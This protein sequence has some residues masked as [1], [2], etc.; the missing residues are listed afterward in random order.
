MYIHKK[1]I[2]QVSIFELYFTR[3]TLKIC[4]HFEP[5]SHQQFAFFSRNKHATCFAS[6]NA[7]KCIH[8]TRLKKHIV[9]FKT[10]VANKNKNRSTRIRLVASIRS[11]ESA[12]WRFA[13]TEN[14]TFLATT[15]TNVF[16][17]FVGRGFSIVNHQ[18]SKTPFFFFGN[19][20][21]PR[22]PR[23]QPP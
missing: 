4:G 3:C 2:F 5:S 22:T 23:K 20:I 14:R 9:T 7:R 8:Y 12:L 11:Y 21:R 1:M 17:V 6:K 16:V 13:V 10:I 18:K 15:N 19:K